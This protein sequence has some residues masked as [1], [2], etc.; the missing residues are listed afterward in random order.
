M[1]QIQRRHFLLASS[2]L[3]AAP[4]AT[5]AQK[6][7]GKIPKIGF[8]ISET[9][10]DSTGRIEAMRAGL[11]DHGYVEGKSAVI[12]IRAADGNYARLP[13]FAEYP[14]EQFW[15]SLFPSQ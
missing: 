5:F 9:V 8:L 15:Q 4:L 7:Q 2:G 6:P 1:K 14:D 3:L 12:E 10:P 13:Q 11:R